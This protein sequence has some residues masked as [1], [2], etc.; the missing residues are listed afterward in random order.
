MGITLLGMHPIPTHLGSQEPSLGRPSTGLGRNLRRHLQSQ[1]LVPI[2]Q[3][4][5]CVSPQQDNSGLA[6]GCYP[7]LTPSARASN[8][9][10][11][12]WPMMARHAPPQCQGLHLPLPQWA[13]EGSR[14]QSHHPSLLVL[15][16]KG[17]GAGS[18]RAHILP[19]MADG[20][21]TPELGSRTRTL[22]RSCGL[23]PLRPAGLGNVGRGALP[24][25]CLRGPAPSP[26]RR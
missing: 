16:Q 3:E 5:T 11:V 10:P 15:G 18:G 4:D 21:R 8:A 20:R 9:P 6:P 23:L 19:A 26:S 22:Y 13:L 17:A 1:A 2:P 25:P 24:P 12:W 14:P 7:A